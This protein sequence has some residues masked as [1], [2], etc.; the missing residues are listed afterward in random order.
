MIYFYLFILFKTNSYLSIEYIIEEVDYSELPNYSIKIAVVGDSGL[1]KS[2]IVRRYV[3][4][5][6]NHD[7]KKNN[8]INLI[9]NFIKLRKK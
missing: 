6:F 2:N 3:Q 4:N 9:L 1:G 5:Y 8:I 7:S